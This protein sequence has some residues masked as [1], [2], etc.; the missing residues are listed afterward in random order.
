M[1]KRYVP[2]MVKDEILIKKRREQMVKAAVK[3]FQEKGFHRTTTREIAKAAGFSIGTL[4]EYIESKED[5]LYLVCDSIHDGVK[6]RF[7]EMLDRNLPGR[8]RIEQLVRSLIHVMDELQDEVL[9]MYQ[10]SKRYRKIINVCLNRD[11]S[12]TE[13][14]RSVLIECREHGEIELSDLEA[15]LLAENIMTKG[16]CGRFAAG[17]FENILRLNSIQTFK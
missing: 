5:V 8:K 3:L 17:H 4:Y 2:A 15:Q 12:M 10:E 1:V 11:R 16:I 14:I 6:T 9:I 7:T 13:G